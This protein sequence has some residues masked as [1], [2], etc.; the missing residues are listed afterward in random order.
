M[1]SLLRSN[2]NFHCI[3]LHITASMNESYNSIFIQL[4]G[5][6]C[7]VWLTICWISCCEVNAFTWLALFIAFISL[8]KLNKKNIC[9]V[10]PVLIDAYH[11]KTLIAFVVC[12]ER[13]YH[14]FTLRMNYFSL[15]CNITRFIHDLMQ[16]P[17]WFHRSI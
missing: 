5:I 3:R 8:V 15:M 17:V 11:W 10:V 14:N 2:N 4:Y 6:L 1:D 16:F 12:F 13:E 9:I 7:F